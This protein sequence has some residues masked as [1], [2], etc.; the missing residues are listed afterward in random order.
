MTT[1]ILVSNQQQIEELL[2]KIG[3]NYICI[4]NLSNDTLIIDY[5]KTISGSIGHPTND[6]KLIIKHN[7]K[8]YKFEKPDKKYFENNISSTDSALILKKSIEAVKD[9]TNLE[10]VL[11][12][13]KEQIDTFNIVI[14][15]KPIIVSNSSSFFMLTFK[16]GNQYL[17]FVAWDKNGNSCN[18]SNKNI[19]GLLHSGD[20]AHGSYFMQSL[21]VNI[22]IGQRML[23]KTDFILGGIGYSHTELMSVTFKHQK[24][25]MCYYDPTTNT[26]GVIPFQQTHSILGTS[27]TIACAIVKHLSESNL[28][29]LP[30][31]TVPIKNKYNTTDPITCDLPN[32]CFA[33]AHEVEATV[34]EVDASNVDAR[35][36]SGTASVSSNELD[37]YDIVDRSET[38]KIEVMQYTTDQ[39]NVL[40]LKNSLTVDYFGNTEHIGSKSQ[41]NP[42]L[43]GL[44]GK[45]TH[46]ALIEPASTAI[47]NFDAKL[48]CLN[49]LHMK[50]TD[51]FSEDCAKL[52]NPIGKITCLMIIHTQFDTENIIEKLE[53]L[54]LSCTKYANHCSVI[55]A[56]CNKTGTYYWIRGIRWYHEKIYKFGDVFDQDEFDVIVTEPVVPYPTKLENMYFKGNSI[57]MDEATDIISKMSFKDFVDNQNDI[58]ELF[59]QMALL[60]ESTKFNAFKNK[61]LTIITYKQAEN[62]KELKAKIV[63]LIKTQHD[64]SVKKELDSIKSNIKKTRACSVL[65]SL[66]QTIL[67]ITA[68]GGASSKAAAKSLQSAM[69]ED[70][71]Y[72]NTS[73]VNS[74]TNEDISDYLEDIESFVIGQLIVTQQLIDILNEVANETYK[75]PEQYIMELHENC[76]ELDGITVS[77]LGTHSSKIPHEL[78]GPASV[79]ILCGESEHVSSVPIAILEIFTNIKDPRY[80]KWFDEVNN[81]NVAKFRILLRRMI[82][83]ATMNRDRSINPGSKSLTY[84]LI[85]MFISLAQ[86][87]KEKFSCIPTDETDFTVLAMR[88]LVGYIFTMCASGTTPITN[89]W[90]VLSHYPTK[91]PGIDSFELKDFWILQ[92]L[93]DMFPYC[94]WSIA[95]PNF[96]KNTLIGITKLL[97]KYIITKELD[98]IGDDEKKLFALKTGAISKDLTTIWQWQKLV[99]ISIIKMLV[100]QNKDIPCESKIIKHVA[101]CLLESYPNI[102]ESI[103]SRKH[104]KS[105]SSVKLKKILE[106]MKSHGN[107]KLNEHQI[108]T[109]KFIIAKRMH[110]YYYDLSKE[111]RTH[112]FSKLDINGIYKELG[113]L[114]KSEPEGNGG[115]SN[116]FFKS[117]AHSYNSINKDI[118]KSKEDTQL[119]IKELFTLESE[120]SSV[121]SAGAGADGAGAASGGAADGIGGGGELMV[122][123]QD[124][125]EDLWLSYNDNMKM[126]TFIEKHKLKDMVSILEYVFPDQNIYDIIIDISGILLDNYK[127]RAKAYEYVV[128]KYTF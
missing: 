13:S 76:I 18:F 6:N 93:I 115:P 98:K 64:P 3:N 31:T 45:G 85:A 74:M 120:D 71:I 55:L 68:D 111:G 5:L 60:Q 99:I 81:T 43:Y 104:M 65:K 124:M 33:G 54:K 16:N 108:K 101:N 69:R 96:K 20:K 44:S 10:D 15:E 29:V 53:H 61:C 70:D 62:N 40:D 52:I 100:K 56:K 12:F 91:V 75:G 102:D 59:V 67:G 38:L 103:I 73:I 34:A 126:M 128:E 116:K 57:S 80:F 2:S 50:E 110:T 113:K 112:Y 121:A 30:F 26:I 58:I 117:W 66:T 39:S 41:F 86:S 118:I 14:V 94:M 83:E 123:Y 7:E 90:K 49:I 87:I 35:S 63:K 79:A 42:S 22:P 48:S 122:R 109:V 24:P 9:Y 27:T 4:P 1:P 92:N 125:R 105:D 28:N 95:E 32:R 127:D 107:I 88:N 77:A 47:S 78:S 51:S 23:P 82:C 84:F 114:I 17:D 106:L 11:G 19:Y 72:K 36:C 46:N 8:I 37:E 21:K 25:C 97:G 89:I 119:S